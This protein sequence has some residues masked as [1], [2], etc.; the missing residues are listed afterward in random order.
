[1]QKQIGLWIDHK[2]A[3]IV[4][5][6]GKRERIRQIHSNVEK[7]VRFKGG[8]GSKTPYSAGYGRGEDQRDRHRRE[9]LN[10]YYGEVIDTIRD[11]H[12]IL[13]YGP[14][15]AKHEFEKRLA[16]ER[17]QRKVAAI[18]AADKLTERQFAAKVR[19]YFQIPRP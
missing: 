18:E 6:E 5:L 2:K 12:S 1:M 9:Q 11:A 4:I 13:I 8:A 17:I 3:V 10:K 14:G 15:E 19:K 7:L 16:H